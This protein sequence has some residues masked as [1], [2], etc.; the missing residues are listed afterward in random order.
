VFSLAFSLFANNGMVNDFLKS[1]GAIKTSTRFLESSGGIYFSM[2]MWYTWKA[3]GWAAIMYIAAIAGIDE[4]LFEAARVD[5]A[6][7]MQVIWHITIP[8]LLPTYFVLLLLQVAS[9]LNNGM[10][11]FY[12]FQN[13]FNKQTIQVLDLYVYNLATGGGSYSLSAG[14]SMLKSIISVALLGV[15]NGLSKSIRGES[16]V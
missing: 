13:A 3:L 2:W 1:I 6:T 4:T 15:V 14:I 11:Q 7:R 10:E 5:G 9:F 16:I 12:V 8:S